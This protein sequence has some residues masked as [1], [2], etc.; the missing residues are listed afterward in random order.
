ME[1]KSITPRNRDC[2]TLRQTNFIYK[3][4][5]LGSWINKNTVKEELDADAE[6]DRMDD[7]NGDKNPYRDLVV[8]NVDRV[9]MSHSP[10]EQWPILSNVINYVQHSRN[11]LNFHFMMIKPAKINKTVKIK[12]KGKILPKVNLIE[13]SGRSREEYLDRYEGIKTEI[14]DTTKVDKNS[15]LSATHLGRIDM[16]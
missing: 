5:E 3:K 15:E 10:M 2:L 4:V 11:P 14:V 1:I 6:L 9:E 8:N 7:N 16:N 12:D 13:C